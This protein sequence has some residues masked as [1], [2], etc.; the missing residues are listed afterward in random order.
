M[1]VPEYPLQ[2]WA[3]RAHPD[4]RRELCHATMNFRKFVTK[5]SRAMRSEEEVFE[6]I[7]RLKPY[8]GENGTHW[9]GDLKDQPHASD[10]DWR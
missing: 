4:W 3:S 7:E 9:D 10:L 1:R 6:I 5:R 2:K 8:R